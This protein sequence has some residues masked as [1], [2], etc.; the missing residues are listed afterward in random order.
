MIRAVIFDIEGVLVN[1][2][3]YQYRAWQHLAHEQGLFADASL[4]HSLIGHGRAESITA[5]LQRANRTYS[6]AE[7]LALSLRKGDLFLEY[8]Q[9]MNSRDVIPGVTDN[10]EKLKKEGIL[11]GAAS[12][13]RNGM[14]ILRKCNLRKWFDAAAD[15]TDVTR[16]KPD[17]ELYSL[18]MEELGVAPGECLVVEDGELGILAAK[19][20]GMKVLAVG[21]AMNDVNTVYHAGGMEAIDLMDLIRRI[22]LEENS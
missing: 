3:E 16:S 5:L 22:N 20:L 4:I 2:E 12:S 6:D 19:K 21:E 1:T 10:L 7:R 14:Y 8:T 15:G 13:S 17:P 9:Q 18:V 11:L